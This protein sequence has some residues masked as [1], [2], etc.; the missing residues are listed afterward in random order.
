MP[1]ITVVQILRKENLSYQDIISQNSKF[2]ETLKVEYIIYDNLKKTD[3]LGFIKKFKYPKYFRKN[4][5]NAKTSLL[6]SG[7]LANGQKIIF[8]KSDDLLTSEN[9]QKLEKVR[10]NILRK[11]LRKVSL[12]KKEDFHYDDFNLLIKDKKTLWEKLKLLLS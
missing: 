11:D 3:V 4:F 12:I 5:K 7:I 1:P 8:L 6:E 9:V 10:P 2:L